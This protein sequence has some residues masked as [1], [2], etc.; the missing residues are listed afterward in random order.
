M[1]CI[2]QINFAWEAGLL[3]EIR[4][5]L[6]LTCFILRDNLR[7]ISIINQIISVLTVKLIAIVI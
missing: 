4:I 3:D 6:K 1:W 7:A 5:F 2:I